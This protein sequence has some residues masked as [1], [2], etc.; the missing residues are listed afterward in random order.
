MIWVQALHSGRSGLLGKKKSQGGRLMT[1]LLRMSWLSPRDDFSIQE[2]FRKLGRNV[3]VIKE[4]II[5]KTINK[6]GIIIGVRKRSGPTEALKELRAILN[7]KHCLFTKRKTV[8]HKPELK[9]LRNHY[10]Q[11]FTPG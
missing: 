7:M 3:Y 4:A 1:L 10:R 9:K 2:N 11:V 5:K 6:V 8:I